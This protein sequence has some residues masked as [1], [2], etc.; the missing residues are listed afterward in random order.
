MPRPL[1]LAFAG[2]VMLGRLVAESLA[3]ARYARPWGDVPA[4]LRDADLFL[5]NL[6]CALTARTTRWTDGAE[7]AF[8]F[9]A[10]PDAVAA[11]TAGRVDCA[12]LANNH[13]GDFGPAGLEDTIAELD[14]AGIAH[15]GAGADRLAARTPALLSAAGTRVAVVAWADYPAEWAAGPQAP[16][17]NYT[18]VSLAPEHFD[19]V[20]LALALARE[21]ADIVVFSIHWGPNM[22]ARPTRE[23][24][25]FAHAVVDA[26]ADVFWGHSAHV[27]QGIEW[28]NGRVIL[29]DTGDLVDDYAVDAHLRNDLSAVFLVRVAPGAALDVDVIPARI[30]DC[31]ACLATGADRDWFLRRFGERCRELGTELVTERTRVRLA[32]PARSAS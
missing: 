15:A 9:R 5:V 31:Q 10:P 13:I 17:I 28:R 12:V 24:Q 23:F 19:E 11:L 26:G 27:V 7:K 4:A 25:R 1:T 2:D 8:Y 3:G 30:A 32:A 16:G 14:R 21:Q 22:R 20:R 18:P 6:E 29:Y